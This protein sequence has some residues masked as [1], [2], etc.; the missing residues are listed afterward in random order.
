[1]LAD[2]RFEVMFL[3]QIGL[4]HGNC[5]VFFMLF[6]PAIGLAQFSA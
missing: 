3:V 6:Y 5:G 1:V 2:F 4:A